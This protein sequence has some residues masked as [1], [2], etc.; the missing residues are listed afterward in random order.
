MHLLLILAIFTAP[1]GGQGELYMRNSLLMLLFGVCFSA[2][3]AAGEMKAVRLKEGINYLD[4]NGDGIKDLVIS[5]Q[6]DNNTSHINHAMT[7]YIR[8]PDGGYSIVPVPD[9]S[10]FSWF[11]F[12]LSAS[13]IQISSYQLY[14]AA[15]GYYIVRADKLTG[16]E[17]GDDAAERLPVKFTRYALAENHDIPGQPLYTWQ[18]RAVWISAQRYEDADQALAEIHFPQ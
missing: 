15:R 4:V 17:Y 7:I 10:G 2:A 18:Q 9:D 11:D 8:K 5:A 6:F 1:S 3:G 13:V 12:S 16:G 14:Q